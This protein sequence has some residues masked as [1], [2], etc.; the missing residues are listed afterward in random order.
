MLRFGHPMDSKACLKMKTL[1]KFTTFTAMLLGLPLL[2]VWL[3][4][5]PVR[6]YLEFPPLTER[7]THAPFSWAVFAGFVLFTL[8]WVAPLLI[9]AVR[10]RRDTA[11]QN[12]ETRQRRFPWWGWLGLLLGS[13]AWV[14]AWTRFPWCAPLQP[15][16]FLPL[17]LA[18]IIVINALAFRRTGHCMLRDRPGFFLL[19]FPISAVFW[20]FFEYLNRFVQNWYYVNVQPGAWNYVIHATLSFATVLPAVLGTREWLAGF[21]LFDRSFARYRPFTFRRPR[22]AAGITLI[23]TSL[24]LAFISVRPD[25]LFALVW[26]SPV[27]IIIAIQTLC[28]DRQIFSPIVQGD[29]RALVTAAAAALICGFF[30]EMWNYPSLTKWIYSVPYAARFHLFE[31][32]LIGY[33]GY[34]PFGLECLVIGNA[35]ERLIKP[36]AENSSPE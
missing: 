10:Y 30:W 20:W 8:C 31:M 24:G 17:W 7:V 6:G 35:L 27:L 16:T 23:L 29:W 9:R 5:L 13:G 26:I 36:R 2:G 1:L 14:L 11:Q 32:P 28:G 4:G 15:H 25:I 3:A 33:A 21:A 12:S 22:L 34:L 18:Y 19:L